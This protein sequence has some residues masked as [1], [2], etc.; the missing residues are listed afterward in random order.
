MMA[1]RYDTT[2]LDRLAPVRGRLTANAA[3][4]GFSWFRVG[5]P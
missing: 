2:L 3:L 1:V 5:G 4:A